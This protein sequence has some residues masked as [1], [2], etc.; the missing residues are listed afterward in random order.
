MFCVRVFSVFYTPAG[1][2][3]KSIQKHKT[4]KIRCVQYSAIRCC[5]SFSH[6][7]NVYKN[8]R[9]T[10]PKHCKTPA[11]H[12][13]TLFFKKHL[14]NT[15][16]KHPQ[17]TRKTPQN[18]AKHHKTHLLTKQ[19]EL[20]NKLLR[21]HRAQARLGRTTGAAA[22]RTTGPESHM[23]GATVSSET[24]T[25][26]CPC[27][28]GRRHQHRAHFSMWYYGVPT[29]RITRCGRDRPT[30]TAERW[31]GSGAELT[32]RRC[33]SLGRRWPQWR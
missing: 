1:N 6:S 15:T 17:S 8:I 18:T 20:A 11:K 32:C 28:Y 4:N 9:K 23:G 27:I 24:E 13:K 10:R 19:T 30:G 5:A 29:A 31:A 14:Q 26:P 7:E 21:S 3:P 2:R 12:R 22:W 33:K 25:H 16:K